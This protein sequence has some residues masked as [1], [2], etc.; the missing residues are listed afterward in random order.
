MFNSQVKGLELFPKAS[1]ISLGWPDQGLTWETDPV[2]HRHKAKKV[3]IAFSTK[4]VKLKEN[5]TH[6]YTDRFV[7]IMKEIGSQAKGV[8]L[9]DV[10]RNNSAR[11]PFC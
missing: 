5:I 7:E 8:E 4:S 3:W 10:G 6:Q 1:F 9:R 11:A 2:W